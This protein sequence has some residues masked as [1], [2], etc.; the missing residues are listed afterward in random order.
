MTELSLRMT[1]HQALQASFGIV[2]TASIVTVLDW[3]ETSLEGIIK[4]EQ[5]QK[6]THKLHHSNMSLFF[7]NDNWTIIHYLLPIVYCLFELVTVWSALANHQFLM[8]GQPCAFD[9]LGSSASLISLANDSRSAR[10]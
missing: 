1:I 7:N 6:E 9:I 4:I 8:S 5:R 3:D 10:F 2:G